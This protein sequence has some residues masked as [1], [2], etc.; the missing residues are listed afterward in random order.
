MTHRRCFEALD[1]TLRDI[2]SE[3]SPPNSI[4]PFGGKPVVLGGDFR[5]ILPVVPKGSRHAVINASITN[6]DLWKNVSILTL[7]INMRL[8]NPDLPVHKRNE[9]R[10]FSEWI[11]AVGNGTV[12]MIAKEGEAYPSWL[13][14]PD[15]LLF[16]TDHD[17]IDA[18]VREIYPNFLA[19]Y[20]NPEYLASRAILCPNNATVD[21]I[22]DYV[23]SLL[24]A[25]GRT[26]L[27]CDTISKVQMAHALISQLYPGDS[28]KKILA[29]VSRLWHFRDLNDDTNILH[30]DLVLLDEVNTKRI[31]KIVYHIQN[32]KGNSTHVQMYRGAIEVLKPLIHEGNVYYIESFT[33][34][35]ANRTYRPV[36]NDFMILFSKWTTLEEC[37]DIPADFPAITFSLTPFQE[38][39]S[40]VDKNIFYVD[41][42]GVI[43]EIS[44]T[45]TVRPRSRDADSLKRTLQICDASSLYTGLTITGS[46]PCKWYINLDIPD[47]LE[48]KERTSKPY[49]STYRCS[50]CCYIGMP[51]PRYKVV[52]TATDNTSEAAFVLFGRIAHRLIH[53]PVESLIEENPPDFILAEIQAL[54]DQAFVWN[55]SFTKHTVKRNQESLQ[56]SIDDKA[57][58]EPKSGQKTLEHPSLPAAGPSESESEHKIKGNFVNTP[59]DPPISPSVPSKSASKK[60]TNT[61]ASVPAPPAK[62]LFKEHSQHT[63]DQ[64]E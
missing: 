50:S 5:Q 36:S 24:P 57:T 52:L 4:I 55:V 25:D 34:K 38:I 28:D 2:L 39:P 11:L 59:D 23:I 54:V 18:I 1:R 61:I 47:V 20:K 19:S 26:Y 49:G 44:S 8:L 3:T 17:K 64:S 42:M 21:E 45:S 30:T 22:N 16:K 46:S 51:V 43:T 48:L 29:R 60:R 53:R 13:T 63:K 31:T 33:V 14:I 7:N 40:L 35:D 41:I 27:S 10:D 6:S 32:L 58:T 56:P 15:D 12:P 9:L 37:I 62:K